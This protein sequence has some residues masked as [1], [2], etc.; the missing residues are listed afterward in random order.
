MKIPMA[1]FTGGQ[2][3]L[4]DPRDV[5]KLLSMLKSTNKLLYHKNINYYNHLDFVWSM[6]AATVVY[7]DIIA[8]AEKI[9]DQV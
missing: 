5:S 8:L 2:D 6:D 9:K 3:W 7:S 4:A 1:L